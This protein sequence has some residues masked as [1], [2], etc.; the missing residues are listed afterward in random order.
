MWEIIDLIVT[1]LLFIDRKV[2]G[3]IT[4]L[5]M[6]YPS[7]KTCKNKTPTSSTLSRTPLGFRCP[8]GASLESRWPPASRLSR[9]PPDSR[10]SRPPADPWRWWWEEEVLP[11]PKDFKVHVSSAIIHEKSLIYISKPSSS[12]LQYASKDSSFIFDGCRTHGVGLWPTRLFISVTMKSIYTWS[13]RLH[14]GGRTHGIGLWP[15][16]LFISFIIRCMFT[17][18]WRLHDGG[19]THGV[20]LWPTRLFVLFTITFRVVPFLLRTWID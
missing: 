13:W 11:P 7:V 4:L 10:L 6:K 3:R 16:R 14:A 1:E 17:W 19:R 5:Q 20:G 18:N 2:V 8:G 15:T 9:W 12:S